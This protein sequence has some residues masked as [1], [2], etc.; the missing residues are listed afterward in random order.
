MKKRQQQGF[1][2]YQL[3]DRVLEALPEIG[4]RI[5]TPVQHQVIPLILQRRNLIVE[6][7][8]GTGKTAAYGLPLLTRLDFLKRSTQVLILVPSRELARQVEAALKSFTKRPQIKIEAVYGGSPLQE[9]EKKVRSS[10]HILIAV[11]ARLKDVLANGGLDH[12]WRDIKYLVIDE[13]D[14]LL[15]MGFQQMIDNLISHLRNMVQVALFS[16]TISRDVEDMIRERFAPIMTIRLSPKEAFRNIRFYQVE[17]EKGQ[18]ARYLAGLI[19]SEQP[20]Q[21][22]VFCGR[23]QETYDL[24]NFLRSAGFSA[25]AY[26]GLMDQVEREAIMRRFQSGLLQYLIAT[27]LAARG[28]DIEKLPAVI[29]VMIPEDQ[30]VYQHRCGRTGRAGNKGIVYNLAAS[31]EELIYLN[32][33]HE[34]MHVR[35]DLLEIEPLAKHQI[36]SSAEQALAKAHLNR[37]KKDKIRPGDI[38]GFLVNTSGIEANDIGTIAIYD[39]YSLVDLPA[40]MLKQLLEKEALLIKGKTVKVTRYTLED[41]KQKEK[42]IRKKQLGV[43]DK[44]EKAKRE[45]Q[46]GKNS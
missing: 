33:F 31:Q 36:R 23:R 11:P 7:A 38:V 22:L 32:Q 8:T 18:L 4:Y 25:E 46:K 12:V 13:A 35:L 6:A 28:L 10:P 29:N 30:E 24:A 45:N 5:P 37:G 1:H 26:H 21:A 14:K 19:T 44:A 16:A 27:D 15:E 17:V 3:D 40:E 41:Q 9:S 42:A 20:R 43:R 2:R 34:I 39:K